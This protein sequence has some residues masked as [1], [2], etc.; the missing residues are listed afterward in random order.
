MGRGLVGRPRACVEHPHRPA[1]DRCDAC[2]GY[3]CAECFVRDGEQL[4]CRDCHAAMP[5]WEAEAAQARRL[6]NRLR[7]AVRDR[8]SGLLAGGVILGLLAAAVALSIWGAGGRSGAVSR[9]LADDPGV[10]LRV[11]TQRYCSVGDGGTGEVPKIARGDARP[12]RVTRVDT[13]A[14]VAVPVDV[15]PDSGDTGAAGQAALA[16]DPAGL[17][18]RRDDYH[19]ALNLTRRGQGTLGWRSRSHVLPVQIGFDLGGVARLDRVAFQH[20]P[21]S[22]PASW[23]REVS[24]LLST[25]APDAGY[26]RVGRWTLTPSTAPQEFTFWETSARYVRL[27]IHST[28]GTADFASLGAVA[29]GVYSSDLRAGSSPLL[30]MPAPSRSFTR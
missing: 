26:Y 28:H 15:L 9:A 22:P 20:T 30:P 19:N 29:F 6:G 25:Q 5:L 24:V 18:P 10:L 16:S 1:V 23:A 3:F 17:G 21:A 4:F 27:C 14:L 2:F 11:A 12:A 13:G 8:L 7:R